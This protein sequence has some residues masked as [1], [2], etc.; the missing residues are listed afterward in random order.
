MIS[1]EEEK[2][3]GRKRTGNFNKNN[4]MTMIMM[5]M[6]VVKKQTNKKK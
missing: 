1:Y 2:L 4:K 6:V 3:S 5:T